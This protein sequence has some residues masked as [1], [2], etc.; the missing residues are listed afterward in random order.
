MTDQ[1]KLQAIEARING[2]WDNPALLKAGPL[3]TSLT[4]DILHIIKK[5]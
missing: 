1:E 2:D 5:E 4:E 3:S